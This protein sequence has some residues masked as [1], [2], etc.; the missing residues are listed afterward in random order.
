[1]EAS[2]PG[3]R[4]KQARSIKTEQVLL[5]A[6]ET[7]LKEK[8][9]FDLTVSEIAAEAGVTTGA[10]YRR[11]DDKQDLLR[12]AFVRFYDQ[13][14]DKPVHDAKQ[15][16]SSLSDR[17]LL[18]NLHKNT[19]QFTLDHI[20]LMR[21]ANALNDPQSFD[22]MIAARNFT[23]DWFA[24][25]LQTSTYGDRELKKR[26]KFVL[27]VTTATF[28]D[29]LLSGQAAAENQNDYMKT[30]SLEMKKLIA[31][32]TEMTSAYLAITE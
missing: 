7:L 28:R 9:F 22:L 14:R 23:A 21:A 17:Q 20:H 31:E 8:S 5:D 11:F 13:T 29:T 16:D 24:G 26:C 19:L 15:F 3:H 32:L 27:R 18:T 4:P 30:H 25:L 1:M 2:K 10:I 6:F 12:S